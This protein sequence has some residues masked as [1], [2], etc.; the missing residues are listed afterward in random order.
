VV[1]RGLVDGPE[2]ADMIAEVVERV[3]GVENVIDQT[4]AAEG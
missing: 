2:D 1:I 4:D 3:S